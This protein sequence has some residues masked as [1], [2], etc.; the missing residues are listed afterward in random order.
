MESDLEKKCKEYAEALGG[1]LP[2]WVSPG[3]RGVHDRILL[4]PGLP[5]AFIEFKWRRGRV[6]PEQERWHQWMRANGFRS[7]S[8]IRDFE[9]FLGVLDE[10]RKVDAGPVPARRRRA[11]L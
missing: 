2:K 8:G 6:K 11:R 3:N 5:V 1:R 9:Q 4:L 7:Y 10:L